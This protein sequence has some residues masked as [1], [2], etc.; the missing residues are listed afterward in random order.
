M[1]FRSTFVAL[2]A[3]ALIAPAMV[4]GQSPSGPILNELEL[5]QA[6]SGTGAPEHAKLT[7][8][9]TALADRYAADAAR[10]QAMAKKYPAGPQKGINPDLRAHCTNLAKRGKQLEASARQ[11]AKMHTSAAPGQAQPAAPKGLPKDLG[12]RKASEDEMAGF[13]EKAA[14]AGDHRALSDYF[15]KLS[16]RYAA[17]ASSHA[18]M[19]T[20]YRTGRTPG[21]ADHCD[22]LSKTAREAAAEA[23]EAAAQHASMK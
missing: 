20:L 3:T 9:F 5:R 12:A 16:E 2:V 14:E 21:M 4:G 11:L 7:A 15:T 22:R 13:A 8:H 17:D 23:K 10:H 6:L 19:A 18:G 1:R